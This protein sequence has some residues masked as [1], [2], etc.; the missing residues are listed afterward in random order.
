MKIIFTI[1][2]VLC[3]TF[4]FAV[5][6]TYSGANGLWNTAANWSPSGVPTG[7]DD[8]II[9]S[10]KIVAISVNIEVKSISVSGALKIND[11]LLFT[12]G[13][14]LTSGSFTVNSGG[15]FTMGSGNDVATLVIFGDYSNSGI[16][17][18]WKSTV[19]ISGNLFSSSTSELQKQGNVVVGGNIIGQFDTTGGNGAGQIYAVNPNATVIIAPTSIDNNVIPGTQVVVPT[20]SQILVDLVNNVIYGGSCLFTISDISN[21]NVCTSRNVVFTSSATGTSPTFIWQVNMGSGWIDLSEG[22]LYSGVTT[23]TLTIT[24]VTAGMN[25][26][27]YRT[28][29]TVASC[30]KNGNY[31]VL[32]VSSSPIISTQ[33]FNELDCEGAFVS[34][35]VVA[36]GSELSYTWQY[37]KTTDGSF[38][39]MPTTN[40]TYPSAGKITIANVGSTQYPNGTQ[41]QV[42]VSNG[43]CSVTSNTV[44]LSVNEIVAINSPALT[45]SQSVVDVKLCYGSNYSYTAV[46]SNPSN[47]PV[48]YQWKSQIPSGSWNNVVDGPH[49]SGA[50]TAVL[51]IINGTPAESGKYRVD[52]VYDRTGG[53]C[54]VSSFA[55]V[56]SLTF[57]PLLTNPVA[58]ISQ[59]DC[60]TNTGIITVMVQSAT[61]VYSFDNGANYQ[62]SN[63]KS[64]LTAGTYNVIIKNIGGCISPVSTNVLIPSIISTWNGG[65]WSPSA[66]T[67]NDKIVFNGNYTASQ[68]LLACSCEVQSGNVVFSSGKILTLT[69]ELKVTSGALIFE[70]K[71]SLVQINNVA[72]SGNITYKRST[73]PISNFDYTYWS[74]A[75]SPQTLYN[76]SP[77]TLGDKFYSFDGIAN[78]WVQE[79]S[80]AT[81]TKG[82]GYIIRGPQ[83][84]AAPNL[85]SPYLASFIGVPNNG[86]ISIPITTSGNAL[87]L[88]GNPYPSALDADAFILNNPVLEGTLYFWTHNTAIGRNVSNPGSGVYAYS[89]DD[90]ASYNLTGGAATST[91][92]K[93]GSASI[94]GA[95]NTAIPSGKIGSAQGFFAGT[96]TSG[97]VNF[98]NS[99]RVGVGIIS[100]DNSQFFKFNSSK[101]AEVVEKNRVWLNLFNNEG[102]FKQTLVGYVTGATNEI[103]SRYDGESFD[104]NK[105]VDFYSI[106]NEKKLVIQGRALPFDK[107]DKVSL[108]YK[109]TIEGAFTIAIDQVDGLFQDQEVFLEDKELNI[110]HN[111]KKGPYTFNT[112]KGIFNNRFVLSYTSKTLSNKEHVFLDKEVVVSNKN[113]EIKIISSVD[114]IDSV[115]V[116][117]ITGKQIYK[118]SKV[119]SN[120]LLIH[121]LLPGNRILIVEVVLQ[122]GKRSSQKIAY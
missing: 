40:V 39:A 22:N 100:G 10:G 76:V 90:Y 116:Y 54:S 41:F 107:E 58:T 81:M 27:K 65:S 77:N 37:K 92:V 5:P 122:N 114:S 69:N 99:I 31:G 30:S 1:F 57:Y 118:K 78:N 52:V 108:G 42:V 16:T 21:I 20:E 105:F 101:T 88:L 68:N 33:P 15:S 47:G 80:S 13:S 36:I 7:S 63:V 51:K 70:D 43:T 119:D 34:F 94:P 62:A 28:K 102:A 110:L 4:V 3:Q 83:S 96:K 26:Y 45:P 73:S 82:V 59:P 74:S 55:K 66:P 117:D 64:G 56:R 95:I 91:G 46:I 2:L 44:V 71:S 24:G 93:A 113:K 35:N 9:P 11:G 19:V 111:L 50:T 106:S 38:L 97:S 79:N 25:N 86:T 18:F 32:T 72:N 104:G 103:D 29:V 121:G 49:F 12:V 53:N 112:A 85:P 84:Y 60:I 67:I 87:Y 115:F 14:N 98:T 61:D 89:G 109:T 120:Q 8:V 23:S 48:T 6:K 17:D 75:V